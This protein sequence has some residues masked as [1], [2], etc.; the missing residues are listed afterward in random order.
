M[1]GC[2]KIVGGNDLSAVQDKK[3][4]EPPVASAF[5]AMRGTS[6]TAAFV[7]KA[8]YCPGTRFLCVDTESEF[9]QCIYGSDRLQD[10]LRDAD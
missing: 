9:V 4:Y 6:D 1:S 5:D 8:T 3:L 7:D 2:I 10:E